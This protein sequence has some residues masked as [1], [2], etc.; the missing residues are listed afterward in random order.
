MYLKF[1]N[2]VREQH[3]IFAAVQNDLFPL[4]SLSVMGVG[5][6]RCGK[7]YL[8]EREGYNCYLMLFTLSGQGKLVYRG[9]TFTVKPDTVMLIDCNEWQNTAP[10]EMNGISALSTSAARPPHTFTKTLLRA[11][12]LSS[13]SAIPL[14]SAPL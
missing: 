9:K 11:T 6:F 14:P 5:E 13:P 1:Q 10:T 3:N 12:A 8:T 2:D 7:N 4:L